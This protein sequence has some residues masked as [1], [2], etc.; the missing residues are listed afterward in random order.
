MKVKIYS[1]PTCIHCKRAK[2]F[3]KEKGIEYEDIDVST[4]EVAGKEM[5]EKS[6]QQ[7]VPVIEIDGKIILGFDKEKIEEALDTK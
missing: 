1:T 2:E 5:V 4:N 6:G 7:A 3:F